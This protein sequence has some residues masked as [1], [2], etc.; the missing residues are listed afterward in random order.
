MH[1]NSA[2][3]TTRCGIAFFYWFLLF[4][5]KLELGAVDGDII[6]SSTSSSCHTRSRWRG[7]VESEL[8]VQNEVEE[9]DVS[10]STA[11]P[12]LRDWTLVVFVLSARPHFSQWRLIRETWADTT[13]FH[14]DPRMPNAT[15]PERAPGLTQ[16]TPT[17]KVLFIVGLPRDK[18]DD[19]LHSEE[20]ERE[21]EINK[22]MIFVNVVDVYSNLIYK[23][24]CAFDV[25][26]SSQYNSTSFVMKVDD[27]TYVDLPPL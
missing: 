20:L 3:C 25:L 11:T 19:V 5:A 27:D 22:D 13:N 15:F 2:R 12:I 21:Q 18:T 26:S 6:T 14:L 23:L 16:S 17:V 1:S 24:V 4:F 10:L 7:G 9:E 8:C